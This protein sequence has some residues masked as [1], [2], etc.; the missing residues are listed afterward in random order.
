M[1]FEVLRI[2]KNYYMEMGED[3]L[4]MLLDLEKYNT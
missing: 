4:V 1:D 3:A 2:R